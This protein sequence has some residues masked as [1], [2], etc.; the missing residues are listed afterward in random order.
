MEEK[1][2]CIK[3]KELRKIGYPNLK[4]WMKN[5]NNL[6]VGRHGRIFITDS[7]TNEKKIFHYS[8]SKWHNPY[9]VG[10]KEG[11]YTLDDS[12]KLYNVYLFNS[13]LIKDINEL[14]GK[15]LGCFC[16]PENMCH[17]KLLLSHYINK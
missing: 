9:K 10:K 1:T 15:I 11:Q 13:G 8:K 5:P 2:Q 17:S 3:V 14:E 6:Y 7:I 12:L 4:V 16:D